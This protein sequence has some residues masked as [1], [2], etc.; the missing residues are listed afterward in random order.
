MTLSQRELFSFI[1]ILYYWIEKSEKRF[2]EALIERVLLSCIS[3]KRI[4]RYMISKINNDFFL[5]LLIWKEY[6]GTLWKINNLYTKQFISMNWLHNFNFWYSWL[7][8]VERQI[9][10]I[11]SD[12]AHRNELFSV[13]IIDFPENPW[14]LCSSP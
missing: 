2:Y 6:S 11:D 9:I 8:I 1:L 5:G 12:S 10:M 7:L 13:L 4:Y 14:I 3:Y